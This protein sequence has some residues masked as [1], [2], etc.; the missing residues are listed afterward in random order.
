MA[1]T[2]G[3]ARSRCEC[4]RSPASRL[5]RLRLEPLA[6]R[7]CSPSSVERERLLHVVAAGQQRR[8]RRA[9]RLAQ[10]AHRDLVQVLVVDPHLL[11]VADDQLLARLRIAPAKLPGTREREAAPSTSCISLPRPVV[12]P[13]CSKSRARR[14]R[15]ARR[16]LESARGSP[17]CA[18]RCAEQQRQ[19]PRASRTR[20]TRLTSRPSRGH[21][22]LAIAVRLHRRDQPG[23]LHLLDQARCAVVADAQM[24]LH[25]RD[26]R[27]AAF[28]A[29]SPPPGRRADRLL[30][31]RSRPPPA[32]PSSPARRLEN[33]FDVLAAARAS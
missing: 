10:L 4:A 12:A 21:Q 7:R 5:A 11:A 26:R 28:A 8:R 24:P 13:V 1:S 6:G 23:A 20:S 19:Q 31:R 25:Q 33:A 16:S 30:R 18:C 29:R 32:S 27:R 9:Q 3:R 2:A 15:R 22:H 14:L 17:A